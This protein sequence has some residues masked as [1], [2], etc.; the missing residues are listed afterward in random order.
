MLINTIIT[1]PLL[2]ILSIGKKS[3]EN[4]GKVIRKSGDTVS[5]L[6]QPANYS[7][8][9]TQTVSQIMFRD[10]KRLF[11]IIDDTLVK[12]I[13]SRFMQGTGSFF[14]TKIGR[15]IT[16]YRLVLGMISDGKFVIPI[17]GAYLFSKELIDEM[18]KKPLTK[19][20]IAQSFV[21]LA[22]KLFPQSKIIV[23]ADGLYATK[24]FL[25]WCIE[26]KIA[27]QMRMHSNRVVF[28]RGE[29]IS[30]KNLL[31]QKGICP[32]GRQM[33]RTISV[34][35]N[36]LNLEITIVRRIDKH[37]EETIVFQVS[38]YKAMPRE[39]VADYK[40]RWPIEKVIRTGKQHLGFEECFSR[41]LD[42]QHN[43]VASVMLAYALAQVEMKK[44][45][46]KTPE[47]AIRRLKTKKINFLK[48][49]FARFYNDN[50]HAHA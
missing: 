12:K 3:F 30:L 39:H 17:N 47:E 27:A 33:A 18:E 26:N 1:Y 7:F 14:D 40:K 29:K 4:M 6:L 22:I 35:W 41:S 16:A 43:H 8:H 45:K 50:L 23:L 10:K 15:R 49:A 25:T 42:V 37:G 38:T 34:V 5:R 19:E 21:T 2:V 11:L 24:N 44:Y 28:Y 36:N 9:Y 20:E 32:K 48:Q 46:L 31:N 13:Y